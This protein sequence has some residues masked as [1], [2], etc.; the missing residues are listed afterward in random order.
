MKEIDNWV[1]FTVLK[2]NPKSNRWDKVAIIENDYGYIQLASDVQSICTSFEE[3][4]KL[5]HKCR[6][7]KWYEQDL[8][9]YGLGFHMLNSGLSC[10]DIDGCIDEHGK[11]SAAARY[12]I[13]KHSPSFIERSVS[14][15]GVHVWVS[16]EAPLGYN[17][18]GTKKT[19]YTFPYQGDIANGEW[20]DSL[21]DR[22]IA[23]T[24]MIFE[25]GA[26]MTKLFV[27][28]KELK[29]EYIKCFEHLREDETPPE[30]KP[31]GLANN[32]KTTQN[33]LAKQQKI[34]RK[35]NRPFTARRV[36]DLFNQGSV[37]ST[38]KNN[39]EENA[40]NVDASAHDIKLL[41]SIFYYL[42]DDVDGAIEV[43]K[44]SPY[45]PTRLEQD[46]K[47]AQQYEPELTRSANT[48]VKWSKQKY[49]KDVSKYYRLT[50]NTKPESNYDICEPVEEIDTND[51]EQIED[52][53][54]FDTDDE[55]LDI[56]S[57]VPQLPD[58]AQIDYNLGKGVCT[59]FD[60][61]VKECAIY[62]P[63]TFVGFYTATVIWA[64]VTASAGRVSGDF[65]GTH[66]T[67]LNFAM[68]AES[69][70]FKSGVA[71]FGKTLVKKAGLGFLLLPDKITP[72]A[73]SQNMSGHLPND[74]EQI[75]DSE[76]KELLAFKV[77]FATSRGWFMDELGKQI[78]C[79]KRDG[80]NSNGLLDMVLSFATEDEY[81]SETKHNGKD[82][83]KNPYL[84]ILGN[85]TPTDI[86]PL[87]KEKSG[88]WTDGFFARILFVTPPKGFRPP[89]GRTPRGY[90]IPDKFVKSL[91]DWHN[92]LGIPE[93]GCIDKVTGQIIIE[94][95]PHTRLSFSNDAYEAIY[96]Y[97][98]GL[99]E[100]S[101][102]LDQPLIKSSYLR[103]ANYA[104]RL[105]ILFASFDGSETVELKHCAKA[106]QVIEQFRG[107]LHNL[108]DNVVNNSGLNQY[109][110]LQ[111]RVGKALSTKT[112]LVR[113]GHTFQE[114]EKVLKFDN[115]AQLLKVLKYMHKERLI[116]SHTTKQGKERFRLT[117]DGLLVYQR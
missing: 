72:E 16:G 89:Q 74:Y 5:L 24:G 107:Y 83:I 13:E 95:V 87:I 27:Q 22:M 10:I 47:T 98:D 86:E 7:G 63:R 65:L 49:H 67:S 46:G 21:S 110:E 115:P 85:S 116:E 71:K 44:Q 114:L 60:E 41:G 1:V 55:L 82:Y 97:M 40:H 111:N 70:W 59:W 66:K 51:D 101:Y 45:Y 34:D 25:E 30:P 4:L 62:A 26:I 79:I 19:N 113:N 31:T 18:N 54:E 69:G 96:E 8:E 117:A 77:C 52:T 57:S 64:L 20:Y 42:F 104:A 38:A 108:F 105:A 43:F 6:T 112:A 99:Q 29:E 28:T 84:A 32:D 76:E 73:L 78:R 50:P 3:A 103:F 35:R 100:L 39:W 12:L 68:I 14:K 33:F 80:S 61:A 17:D 93:S 11:V 37:S 92:R 36:I 109:E 23:I 58:Y 81:G 48:A 88:L 90:E 9:S 56:S 2:K 15:T 53:D 91:V 75:T 102:E 106:Q 94:P